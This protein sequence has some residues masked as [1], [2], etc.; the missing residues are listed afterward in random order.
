MDYILVH[1][2]EKLKRKWVLFETT[3]PFVENCSFWLSEFARELC[4]PVARIDAELVRVSAVD[5]SVF[6]NLCARH[7]FLFNKS[8]KHL[9]S[10]LYV[11]TLVLSLLLL[12]LNFLK[13]YIYSCYIYTTISTSGSQKWLG[14][15]LQLMFGREQKEAFSRHPSGQ[16]VVLP[17]SSRH[18]YV[19][20]L[21][22]LRLILQECHTNILDIS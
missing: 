5:F 20:T 9:H 13:H 3:Q 17:C 1:S 12:I 21:V 16:V 15:R 4:L 22:H 14:S 8:L 7:S 18:Y 11:F 6:Q 2:P 19:I 10:I